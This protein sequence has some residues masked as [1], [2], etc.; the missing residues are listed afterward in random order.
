MNDK[1]CQIEALFYVIS[2]HFNLLK[3]ASI[4]TLLSVFWA[5]QTTTKIPLHS[6]S[7]WQ[8]SKMCDF[9]NFM[10]YS[11]SSLIYFFSHYAYD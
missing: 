6:L 1:G 10:L 2:Y 7:Y 5:T 11:I 3:N 4:D 9:Y 8:K